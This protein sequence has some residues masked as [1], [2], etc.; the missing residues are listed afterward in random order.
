MKK[1]KGVKIIKTIQS[2]TPVR[3]NDIGGWTDTWFA[4]KGK[5]LNMAVSPGVDVSIK[6]WENIKNEKE[7]V[8]IHTQNYGETFQV[9]PDH[10][11]YDQ[12]PL[13]QAAIHSISVPKKF[14][15]EIKIHS[16]IP[17]GSSTGTSA[18]VCAALLG[19]L[20]QITPHKRSASEIASLAHQ[21]ETE[22]LGWQS[23][24]QD[25]I[26]AAY[27]GV[28]FVDMYRYPQANVTKLKL[29]QNI[30][31]NLNQRICLVYL[32]SGHSS[33]ALHEEVIRF[34]EKKGSQFKL[35]HQ[36]RDLAQKARNLLS[37]GDL[38]SFGKTMIDN[39]ECQR[40]L[41][42]KLISSQAESVIRIAQK[43]HAA[44]WKVNGAGGQGGS[45]T[46]LSSARKSE[47]KEMLKE[48]ASL[49]K[50]I[51]HIPVSLNLQGLK[52]STSS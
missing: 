35:I 37:Q 23:G 10:P 27:G 50:G 7:R 19:A 5:V 14:K 28:C 17:A 45:L 22:K 6:V 12:H 29:K 13:L 24:I 16:R 52:V 42:S 41:H 18:S 1:S 46:L 38:E 9:D 40:S 34:L 26:C 39:N 31:K 25:Q 43:H 8:T 44:G 48:I 20:D 4:K 33:S 36:M 2:H 30:K 15:L 47:K 32:G 21:V 51:Q 11:K 49:G 3:I